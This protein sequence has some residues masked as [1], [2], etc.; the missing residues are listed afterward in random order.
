MP[1]KPLARWKTKQGVEKLRSIARDLQGLATSIVRPEATAAAVAS[2]HREVAGYLRDMSALVSGELSH[3]DA[4]LH[5][6]EELR[7]C[8][9]ILTEWAN[10]PTDRTGN[11]A[12]AA[13]LRGVA[14]GVLAFADK[15]Q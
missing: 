3:S 14:A 10:H 9:D 13:Q 2:W 6:A 15:I 7:A 8:A 12:R 1:N 4:A 5:Q 11:H